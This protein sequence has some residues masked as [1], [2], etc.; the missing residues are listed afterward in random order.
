MRGTRIGLSG[1]GD[2]RYTKRVC[3]HLAAR[4]R[5]LRQERGLSI[6]A[7]ARK[8]RLTP[9]AVLRFETAPDRMALT[10]FDHVIRKLGEDPAKVMRNICRLAASG[11]R[12]R[13]APRR[14][15]TP[16]D[17]AKAG[18]AIRHLRLRRRMSLERLSR[19]AW[20][21][22]GCLEDAEAGVIGLTPAQARRVAAALSMPGAKIAIPA[23]RTRTRK[24]GA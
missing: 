7:L 8:T 10:M 4:L 6:C 18:R 14:R 15:K 2:R 20:L 19:R 16:R 11:A 3:E 21:S 12:A 5:W 24:D 1:P 22:V 17:D 13:P 9:H 23:S